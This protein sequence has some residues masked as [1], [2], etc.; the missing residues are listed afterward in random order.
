MVTQPAIEDHGLIG[1]LQT[2]ALVATDGTID[3][4]CCPRFDSPSVFAAI[5]DSDKGGYFRVTPEDSDYRTKQLYLPGT[6][7]LITRFI[8]ASGVGEVIDFMPPRTG[9]ASEVHDVVRAIRATRGSVRFRLECQ[10]RFDY[11]REKHEVAITDEGV[12][13]RN[14]VLD[15]ALLQAP[16]RAEL[17]LEPLEFRREGDGVSASFDLSQGEI[18]GIVLR[19]G[20]D[21]AAQRLLPG[22]AMKA[23]EDTAHFW[24][25]WL[26][27]STY[28]GRWREVVQRSA[29]T[30]KLMTYAP[31]GGIVAAPTAGLP[32]QVGGERNWDYRYSWVRDS[33][34]SVYALLALGF[35]D[36]AQAFGQWLR[37]RVM[38]GID[39]RSG[40]LRIMYRVDGS[41]DLSEETLSHFE[42]WRHSRP[43]RIGNAAADQLQLDIYGE[44]LDAIYLAVTHGA[45][46]A[47]EGWQS[48]RRV[49]DWLCDHWDQ[50]EEGIWETRG[51][52]KDFTYGRFQVWIA[53]DRAIRMAEVT[54]KPAHT[55]KWVKSRDDVYEQVMRR[56]WNPE[57]KA[58]VQHYESDVLDASLLLMPLVGFV[59]PSDPLWQST[60]RRIGVELLS[61]SL[62]Y[63]YNP[64]ASPDGLRGSEGTFSMCSFWY[65][66]ALARSGFLDQA[67][68]VF[69]KML[70]YGNH[71]GLCSEEVGITGEQLGNFPQAFSHLALINAAINLDY[72]LDHGP[73][74]L[75]VTGPISI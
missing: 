24:Q 13:F 43:V 35:V 14:H 60:L 34:F 70:T 75:N 71:L 41:S 37:D 6:A 45:G 62:V 42:G 3:W 38:S 46:I 31:T 55:A 15:M 66:D 7:I 1:D 33:S 49:I 57:K 8:M 19:S 68:M 4:Y 54:G 22:E 36:E 30:L 48:L 58:F 51:G 32:E 61:D 63:R 65:V 39:G 27:R 59:A 72:Q 10:P 18:R 5:L 29:I 40:P 53:L 74:V 73:G 50:S 25:S 67:R 28:S 52:Q 2:A 21:V 64:E 69:E 26:A 17:A 20:S 12:L 16:G 56:G 47:H 11:A 44:S 23:Y 9:G